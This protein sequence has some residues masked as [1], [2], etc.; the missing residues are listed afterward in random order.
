MAH[1]TDIE[2]LEKQNIQQSI[3]TLRGEPVMLDFLLARLYGVETRVLK[4][5]VRRNIERFPEDFMFR[6]SQDECKFLVL[7]GVS[8]FVIPADY[9]FG[10]STPFAFTEQGVAMLSSVLRSKV[11]V[12]INIDIMRAFVAARKLFLQNKEHEMAISELRIK[13]KML[14]D[15]LENNL[16][17]VND[18]SEQ[19]RSELD[20]IYNAIGAL[21]LKQT[22]SLKPLNPI[23]Y[24]AIAERRKAG[25]K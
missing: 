18:L 8:Q 15:A 24:E 4:Q 9:N 11:A 12:Q 20:D 25:K 7:S 2:L 23:G 1:N 5:A 22:T 13:M 14:E 19:M 21:S 6:L 16:G 10:G 17:A 3:V